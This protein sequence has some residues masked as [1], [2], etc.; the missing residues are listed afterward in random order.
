MSQAG[1][2]LPRVDSKIERALN[3]H[4]VQ[5]HGVVTAREARR[6]GMTPAE[7]RARVARGRWQRLHAGV[8]VPVGTPLSPATQLTAAVAGAGPS[9]VASHASAAWLWDLVAKAP[10]RPCV[11]VPY[12]ADADL[13]GVDIH[14]RRGPGRRPRQRQGIAVTDVVQTL[15]DLAA[16]GLAVGTLDDLTDKAIARRQ[17][18]ARDLARAVALLAGRGRPGPAAI[19]AVCERRGLAE[20]PHPSVLESQ[21]LRLLKAWGYAPIGMERQVCG[22]RYCIDFLLAPGLVLEVDGFAY[23]S[24]PRARAADLHRRNRIRAEGFY[25]I[26]SDWLTVTCEPQRLR[27]EI[28]SALALKAVG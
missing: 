20:P 25:I 19:R 21:V 15:V 8:Y 9:A 26:E 24:S 3:A 11:T 2:R 17:V 7:I 5:H 28:E 22:G 1:A 12:P 16:S 4:L 10:A 18:Q 13:H 14:R 27:A 6:L 23:H